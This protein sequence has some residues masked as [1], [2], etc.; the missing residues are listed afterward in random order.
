MIAPG[1]L[2]FGVPVT[3]G[4]QEGRRLAEEELAKSVYQNAKPSLAAQIWDW[5][6]KTLSDFINGLHGPNA[7]IS[8]FLLVAGAIAVLAVAFFFI[9]PRLNGKAAVAK[10]DAIFDADKPLTAAEHRALASKYATAGDYQQALLEQFR[11]MVRKCEERAVL[12]GQPGR[13]A[14]EVAADASGAF[15]TF[16]SALAEAALAF[17]RVRYGHGIAT[18]NGYDSLRQLDLDLAATPPK[19]SLTLAAP[20]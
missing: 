2:H 14:Q 13:T 11:A 12:T 7:N 19:Y 10:T 4:D 3:P 17:N 1:W 5:I 20:R 9:R 8:A 18:Q 6:T 16:D 15:P